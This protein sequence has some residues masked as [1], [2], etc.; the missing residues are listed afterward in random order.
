M[1]CSSEAVGALHSVRGW[2]HDINHTEARALLEVPSVKNAIEVAQNYSL[3]VLDGIGSGHNSTLVMFLRNITQGHHTF[4]STFDMNYR[5]IADDV[6]QHIQALNMTDVA[7]NYTKMTA[8]G[9]ISVVVKL[10][11]VV[12]IAFSTGST[13]IMC[14]TILFLLLSSKED[15]MV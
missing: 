14:A 5:S 4:N 3:E 13:V 7:I 10:I 1:H 9:A 6:W 12:G 15:V 11:A 8:K 2:I